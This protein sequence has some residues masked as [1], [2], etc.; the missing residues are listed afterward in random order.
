[1]VFGF[2]ELREVFW[3]LQPSMQSRETL[4]IKSYLDPQVV[5]LL[6]YNSTESLDGQVRFSTIFLGYLKAYL[7]LHGLL[8]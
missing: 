5:Q 4:T 3:P 2:S 6:K 1:M 7:L 8:L